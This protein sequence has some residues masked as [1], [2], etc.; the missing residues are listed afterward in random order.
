MSEERL[1][2]VTTSNLALLTIEKEFLTDTLVCM[3]ACVQRS[4]TTLLTFFGKRTTYKFEI[5]VH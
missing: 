3:S 5:H 1:S 2:S 4:T